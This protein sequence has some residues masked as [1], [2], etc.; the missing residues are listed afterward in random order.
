MPRAPGFASGVGG[1]ADQL[2]LDLA[3]VAVREDPVRPDALVDLAEVEVCL[4]VAACARH[5]ALRIDHDIRDEPG[6]G[7][8]GQGEDRRGRV[9]A[10]RADDGAGPR[11]QG[12][13]LGAMELREAVD[14]AG[15][16]LRPRVVEVVPGRVVR[17]VAEPEVRPQVDDGLAAVEELVDPVRNRSVREG[18][19][20]GLCVVGHVVVHAQV[21]RGEVRVEV[22]DGVALALAAHEA[23]DPHVRVQRQ[24]P[25]QLRADVPGGTDDRDADG[26]AAVQGARATFRRGGLRRTVRHDRRAVVPRAHGR[27]SP[28]AGGRQDGVE[29]GRNA[30]T[31]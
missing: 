25:D 23:R 8:R 26:L 12:R 31:E 16:E 1:L 13:Q 28:L 19:E 2:L 5:A 11:A 18:E 4:G 7:E 21:P 29:I 24:E 9:A 3:D 15:E 17:R 20:D 14:R 30:V 10:R 22:R 27:V 6:P